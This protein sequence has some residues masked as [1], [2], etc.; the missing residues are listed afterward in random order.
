MATV[1]TGQCQTV[2]ELINRSGKAKATQKTG[3]ER[4][5][6]IRRALRPLGL[7]ELPPAELRER[8]LR[9]VLEYARDRGTM[10]QSRRAI[11]YLVACYS[12][13]LDQDHDSR[14]R[15]AADP[16]D[17]PVLHLPA[18]ASNPGRRLTKS[19]IDQ[20]MGAPERTRDR[21]TER[22]PSCGCCGRC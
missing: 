20:L 2:S 14:E 17:R 8:H 15:L 5:A 18:D 21:G 12:W 10:V 11:A 22:S 9:A 13:A 19:K 6:S 3:P 4:A 16:K 7:L 1:E